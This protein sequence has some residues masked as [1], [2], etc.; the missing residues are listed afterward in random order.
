MTLLDR[1]AGMMANW[2]TPISMSYV[3]MFFKS[4]PVLTIDSGLIRGQVN[5]LVFDLFLVAVPYHSS[6]TAGK[7]KLGADN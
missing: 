3:L 4:I 2:L 5:K 6:S 7:K 1:G